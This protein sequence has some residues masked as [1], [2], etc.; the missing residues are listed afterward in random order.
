MEQPQQLPVGEQLQQIAQLLQQVVQQQS[1]ILEQLQLQLQV[2]TM[3]NV[4]TVSFSFCRGTKSH[5]SGKLLELY[6]G[7]SLGLGPFYT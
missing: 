4:V 5:A 6:E 2:N 7:L 3:L 1:Q